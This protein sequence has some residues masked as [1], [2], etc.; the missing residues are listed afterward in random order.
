MYY[1]KNLKDA[2]VSKVFAKVYN[3]YFRFLYNAAIYNQGHRK[4]NRH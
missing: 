3:W 2:N 4:L 1:L